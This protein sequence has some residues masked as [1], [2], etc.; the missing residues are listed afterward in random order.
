MRIGDEADTQPR[1]RLHSRGHA[2]IDALQ[3][4]P[5]WRL[6]PRSTA[7]AGDSDDSTGRHQGAKESRLRPTGTTY[8]R[9]HH[10]LCGAG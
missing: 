3:D 6:V 8:P 9:I 10:L 1:R 7:Q 5:V 4:G 2:H